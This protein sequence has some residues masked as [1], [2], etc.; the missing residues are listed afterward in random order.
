MR[1]F[2]FR[3]I[4]GRIIPILNKG[5]TDFAAHTA[6]K[7]LQKRALKT[8]RVDLE[9]D[10]MPDASVRKS[11]EAMKTMYLS[12]IEVPWD[13][14]RQGIGSDVMTR[15]N[16]IADK[17]KKNISLMLA[18]PEETPWRG[19]TESKEALKRFYKRHGFIDNTSRTKK[20][21]PGFWED[22]VRPKK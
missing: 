15:L 22:M 1:K 9:V 17:Y 3:R 10:F 6:I 5:Q 14:H 18:D 8:H 16:K 11:K 4:G 12:R 7:S 2:I 20:A 19:Y 13:K 21:L